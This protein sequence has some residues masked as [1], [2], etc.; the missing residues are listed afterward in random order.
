MA[1]SKQELSNNDRKILDVLIENARQSLIEISEKTG[2][3]RQTVQKTISKLERE[4]VIW[5][6]YPVVNLQKMGKKRFIMLIKTS[7]Q[8]TKEKF[9]EILPM[10]RKEITEDIKIMSIYVGITH[11]FFDG[12][13]IFAAD[14]IIMAN[15]FMR[16]MKTK[17]KDLIENI[18]LIEELMTIR[19]SS[20]I[21]PEFKK[22][23]NEIL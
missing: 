6:Y 22:E 19:S 15:K 20:F 13:V 14:D 21:N 2:L 3:S 18:E 23:I 16:L 4:H 17:Y 12:I 7:S 5:G 1:K 9:L 8:L 10:G 11:G